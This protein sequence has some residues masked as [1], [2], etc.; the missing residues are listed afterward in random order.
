[1]SS[2]PFLPPGAWCHAGHTAGPRSGGGQAGSQQGVPA[3]PDSLSSLPVHPRELP[4]PSAGRPAL[5]SPPFFP[6]ELGSRH[7]LVRLQTAAVL[8]A[9]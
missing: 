7:A 1:M 3:H 8:Q 9:G 6:P 5:P 4:S 2:I